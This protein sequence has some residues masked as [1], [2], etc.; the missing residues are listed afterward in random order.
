[1]RLPVIVGPTA[2]GKTAL[3]LS[4]AS[5]FPRLVVISADSR[6]V[7]RF[8]D[9]G[10]AKP[11]KEELEALPHECIDCRNPDES[12]SAGE[13]GRDARQRI[14]EHVHAGDFPIVVGGSGLY[15]RA[16]VDG[17]FEGELSDPELREMLRLEA[18][19]TGLARLYERLQRM[20]PESAEKIHPNDEQRILRAL[21][22]IEL[23]GEPR[24]AYLKRMKQESPYQPVFWGLTM[25]RSALYQRIEQRVDRM[26]A[27]G[28][29][30]EVLRLK[31]MGY[32]RDLQS[33]QTVGYR[34]IYAYLAGEISRER[35]VEEIKQN[36]RRFAKRQWT[37]FRA[38]QRIQW[39]EITPETDFKKLAK[40]L[41]EKIKK[42]YLRSPQ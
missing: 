6:Q 8:M 34:E 10:T 28:L 30:E 14:A 3:A 26:M 40:I 38:D 22:L 31:E 27:M 4:L 39:I 19:T 9:I 18:R 42:A 33:M 37:W 24:S 2:V 36:T 7:Y 1:M 12:Y 15:I 17:L 20:D 29:V 35:A 21:E 11:T 32:G 41:S 13:F 5:H 16:C 25:E 23:T